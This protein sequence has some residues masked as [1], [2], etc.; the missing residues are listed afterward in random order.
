MLNVQPSPMVAAFSSRGPNKVTPYIL[1]PN[2]I[3]PG[4]NIS[5][6]WPE[7]VGPTGLDTDTRKTPFN[8]NSSNISSNFVFLFL[9][10]SIELS[11]IQIIGVLCNLQ[12]YQ[13]INLLIS[14]P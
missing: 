8:I 3:G 6:A 2:V 7:A 14:S 5:V 9:H 10:T 12:T 1:K 4:V 13:L 11:N